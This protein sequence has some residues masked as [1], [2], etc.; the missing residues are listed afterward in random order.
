MRDYPDPLDLS[1][2]KVYPLASRQ[3]LSHIDNML[4]D[5][6]A[7]PPSCAEGQAN[8]IEQCASKIRQARKAGASVMLM[9]G[10]HLVKNGLLPVVN[11]LLDGGHVTHLATNG[12]GAIHDWEL[13]F[14][15]RTEE[16]VRKNVA[17]GTFGTWDETS[18]CIHLALMCGALDGLGYGQSVGRL[19]EHEGLEIPSPAELTRL[20]QLE[21]GHPLTPARADLLSGA[22]L[23]IPAGLYRV[24]HPGKKH[25][26]LAA[27]TTSPSVDR[28]PW[29]R[30]RHHFQSPHL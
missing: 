4:V 9:Y 20:I 10:A 12:A 13:A 5:A 18:R 27:R 8:D 22:K 17:T 7:P 14:L 23:K 30:L 19:I 16:S 3:S 2:L 24:P 11:G 21:P 25:P 15:G 26:F 28:P 1:R 29:D 6:K